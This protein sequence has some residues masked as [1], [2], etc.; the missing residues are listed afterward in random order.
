MSENL[1]QLQQLTSIYSEANVV[2]NSGTTGVWDDLLKLIEDLFN[3]VLKTV[4]GANGRTIADIINDVKSKIDGV[5]ST[6]RSTVSSVTSDIKAALSGVLHEVDTYVSNAVTL[7]G[8]KLNGVVNTLSSAISS[9]T[10]QVVSKVSN[11]IS[12]ITDGIKDAIQGL[13]DKIGGVIDAISNIGAQIG[14]TISEALANISDFIS[15]AISDAIA[16]TTAY[17]AQVINDVKSWIT[18]VYNAVKN[19]L[20]T[21]IKNTADW[22]GSTYTAIQKAISDTIAAL[23][24][25]YEASKKSVIDA[26]NSVLE[27][28]KMIAD[29][30]S[31][32]FWARMSD[33]GQWIANVV[34]PKFGEIVTAAQ[35][36]YK[37]GGM[38]WDMI[39]K[40]NYQGAF[41]ILDSFFSQLGTPAPVNVLHGILSSIAYFWETVKLQF[42]PLEVAAAKR[43]NIG[44]ALDPI[45]S[46]EA[47]TA[48]FKGY[49]NEDQFIENASLG[50]ISKD[51]ALASI[52]A[53]K[54][55]PTPG[56]AQQLFLRGEI[57][58]KKHDSILASYGFSQDH[59]NEI[60]SLYAIIP[61]VTDIITMAVKEAFTPEIAQR[62]GQ[63]EDL[64]PAFVSWAKKQGLSEE[65][66]G[67]YW[68]AHWE[69]PSPQMGFEMYQRRLI[70]KDDLTLLL[71][72]LDVMPYWR[73]KMIN[74]SYNPPT[75]VDVRRMYKM[76]VITE[77]QVYNFHL[78]IGYSPENA[79]LLTDF[80][81]RYSAPEDQSQQDTF[82]ELARSTY[83]AAYKDRIISEVE[84]RTFLE[85]LKYATDDINLL[86]TL[87]DY[88]IEQKEALF[89]PTGYRK[90][91]LKMIEQG[92]NRGLFNR[93]D[94]IPMLLDLGLTND[95]AEL[96][97]SLIDYN[98]QLA[99]K[100]ILLNQLHDQYTTFIIDGVELHSILDTFAFYSD[101]VERLIQEWDIER[102]FRTKKPSETLI[103][104]FLTKG[105][106]T[107]D[108]YLDELRGF[109]YHEKYIEL[110]A[111]ALQAN[112]G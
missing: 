112:K 95:Q 20:D 17:I 98:R 96:E 26:F 102:S 25:T 66:A 19:W 18:D 11:L 47:A 107:E 73:E 3:R 63:F 42:V 45:S 70:D 34:L 71:K 35:Q 86:I 77:E 89:D 52:E 43:A 30:L 55:L 22:I 32:F 37:L 27:W 38:G 76:G 10:D 59:I 15:G 84:Y 99:V 72:A 14:H 82:I 75:R 36:L 85:G 29:E 111:Q 91:Y 87:D 40:G 7:I 1:L 50:G 12:S 51:R 13:I 5:V 105:L 16:T 103:K 74:L 4:V 88:A 31:N 94:T 69:L 108:Q 79:R 83:S 104:S 101:E 110:F 97:L 60:K 23:S 8:N 58:E 54:A 90:D 68:A 64:P 109:G 28:G 106:I 9:V 41:D 57:D 61:S 48:L 80:T 33:V 2:P 53:N 24:A 65:W 62:F 67:R 46:S 49:W 93:Q 92:Y 44:L 39:Q 78:D 100:D 56:Q 6:V 81:K 21:T